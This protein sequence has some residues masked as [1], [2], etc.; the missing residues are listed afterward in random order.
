MATD[1]PV[2][3]RVFTRLLGIAL[4]P[5]KSIQSH[6]SS[7]SPNIAHVTALKAELANDV[8]SRWARPID[9][10][11]Q[12]GVTESWIERLCDEKILDDQ[13]IGGQFVCISGNQRLC[14][15]RELVSEWKPLDESEEMDVLMDHYPAR[16]YRNG[17]YTSVPFCSLWCSL[18]ISDVLADDDLLVWMTEKNTE[19]VSLTVTKWDRL[20]TV[21]SLADPV[22]QSRAL[23]L[24]GFSSKDVPSLVSVRNSEVWP[25]LIR[26]LCYPMY[27]DIATGT[28][29]DWA[30]SYR[31]YPVCFLHVVNAGCK[32][33]PYRFRFS[34]SS[35]PTS[36]TSRIAFVL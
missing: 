7:R 28:I 10:V 29:V 11:I 14:A 9:V 24:L 25:L 21:D 17:L 35:Y 19:R 3:A 5:L 27:Q 30:I 31:S 16:V 34:P 32:L 8:C 13:N 12:K 2:H 18:R 6:P 33:I 1:R 4:I 26:L 23:L 22:A 20:I 15:A 36:Y